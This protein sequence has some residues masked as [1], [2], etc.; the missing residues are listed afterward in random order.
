M[1]IVVRVLYSYSL[2]IPLHQ[3][4]HC[5]GFVHRAEVETALQSIVGELKQ[6]KSV[7][8]D[9]DTLKRVVGK[10]AENWE[11]RQLI[12]YEL[13]AYR[14]NL[15]PIVSYTLRYALQVQRLI[16]ILS[17][18]LSE[19][20]LGPAAIHQKCLSCDKPLVNP[21]LQVLRPPE[22]LL[23]SIIFDAVLL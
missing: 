18:G 3:V 4:G 15:Y 6:L 11:V 5:A 22:P 2:P 10:K 7:A 12:F 13:Y 1:L 20:A 14:T 21:I 16:S 19:P 8:S 17:G 23:Y 9:M